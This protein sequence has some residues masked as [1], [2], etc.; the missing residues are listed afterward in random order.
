M[1]LL[2]N[3]NSTITPPTTLYIPKSCTPKEASIARV[4]YKPT[5]KTM[6]FFKS[7]NSVFFAMILLLICIVYTFCIIQHNGEYHKKR[8][9][10]VTEQTLVSKHIDE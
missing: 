6:A 9:K 5:N 2:I 3:E 10:I 1:A 4:V 8:H 7:K